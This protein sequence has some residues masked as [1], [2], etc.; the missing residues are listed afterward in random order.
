MG[1]SD[2]GKSWVRVLL[3][4]LASFL[5]LFVVA[6]TWQQVP[7]PGREAVANRQPKTNE[8][9]LREGLLEGTLGGL[10]EL[11][12]DYF[13]LRAYTFWED[14]DF[15][16][17]NWYMELG[18]QMAPKNR[19]MWRNRIRVVSRDMPVWQ[20]QRSE[21][22]PALPQGEA[23]SIKKEY[24]ARGLLLLSELQ[25]QFPQEPEWWTSAGFLYEERM[26]DVDQALR[27]FM[28]AWRLGGG[29]VNYRKLV[30]L[31]MQQERYEEAYQFLQSIYDQ[32]PED[33]PSA[34]KGL[35]GEWLLEL[36]AKLS[37]L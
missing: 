11:L 34:T 7:L 23:Q 12:A 15:V 20:M 8:V 25:L 16:W 13:W 18:T 27:C 36:E 1:L 35:A 28:N 24:A 37:S 2:E 31:W 3:S 30:M 29:Y 5:L 6:W 21:A 9:M 4:A 17:T 26:G 33:L 32:L 10:R 19:S 14:K 22:W